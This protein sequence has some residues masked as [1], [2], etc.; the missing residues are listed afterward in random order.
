MSVLKAVEHGATVKRGDLL[1]ALD[2]EKIDRAIADQ[3]KDFQAS[4]L[5]LK[6]AEESLQAMEK[7]APLDMEAAEHA[8]RMAQEDL[9]QFL[10]VDRPLG[11]KSAA[12]VLKV[13]KDSLEY[14]EEELR[15]LQK[16]YK[17]DEAT[18]DT[19]KIVLKR[20]DNA[21]KRAKFML[22]RTQAECDEFLKYTI[23][24]RE[25]KVK[26]ATQRAEIDWTRAKVTLPMLLSKQRMEMDK[27]RVTHGRTE[28]HLRKLREDRAIMTV[29]SPTNGVVYY[30]KCVRGKWSGL[31]TESLRR[32]AS[33]SPNEV[34]M[35]VVQPRPL[36]VR[37]TVPESQIQ[38]VSGGLQA[39]VEPA[40]FSDR[41]L[42]AIVQRVGTV[43]IE[44]RRLR[45]PAYRGHRW[46]GRRRDARH[47][48]RGEAGP[49]QEA[50]CPDRF[51]QG[52]LH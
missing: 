23:P 49:L 15:Q 9:K 41:R 1:L 3:E 42:S 35:T 38:H 21:V 10:E 43:P 13:A 18:E 11:I 51:A 22:E 6:Q 36:L 33:I 20:A 29:K 19:E 8:H 46:P 45:R 25:E 30:G 47:D 52:G 5:A 31:G 4:A 32:D 37:V 26:E 48:V 40:G 34:F 7:A 50:G 39:V 28:E 2:L 16:M 17:A 27:L 24:R 12:V 14:D 44:L